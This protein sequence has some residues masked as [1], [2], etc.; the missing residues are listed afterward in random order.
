MIANATWCRN[1]PTPDTFDKDV[2]TVRRSISDTVSSGFFD[3][4]TIAEDLNFTLLGCVLIPCISILLFLMRNAY[5]RKKPMP[6]WLAAEGGHEAVVKEL[7]KKG[8][9]PNSYDGDGQTALWLA[10]M[11]GHE[12]I[13]KM[14]LQK[15][16]STKFTELLGRTPL[17]VASERGHEGIARLLLEY[18]ACSKSAGP[19][20]QDCALVERV[21]IQ[22]AAEG[23]PLKHN[24]TII[25]VGGDVEEM[26]GGNCSKEGSVLILRR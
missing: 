25:I 10:A 24:N 8:E 14:L 17:R 21:G 4:N 22:C 15:G 6:L 9:N 7:L 12:A 3:L 11:G 23:D 20:R 13:V 19:I 16:A 26:W 1:H 5:P 18:D 2:N